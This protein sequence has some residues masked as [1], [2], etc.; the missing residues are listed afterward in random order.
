[1][2]IGGIQKDEFL[3]ATVKLQKIGKKTMQLIPIIKL[4]KNKSSDNY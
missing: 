2:S 4:D 3:Y 1:M